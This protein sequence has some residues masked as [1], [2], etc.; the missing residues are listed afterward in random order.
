MKSVLVIDDEPAI[1]RSLQRVLVSAGYPVRLANNGTD[2]LEALKSQI[3]DIVIVDIIMPRVNGVD[4]IRAIVQ[5]FP[6]VR[7]IAISGGGN[8]SS[9]EY[10]PYAIKT[11]AYLAAATV[12]GA[13]AVLTKPFKTQ[14]VIRAIKAVTDSYSGNG[15]LN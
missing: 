1:R 2:G 11:E 13:H 8:F 7:I 9:A 5:E 3:V 15:E 4:T 6:N 10:Q 14:D 12:A